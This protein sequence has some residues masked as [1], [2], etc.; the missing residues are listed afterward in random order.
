MEVLIQQ[1]LKDV[2]SN[3]RNLGE[4]DMS[5]DQC[6]DFFREAWKKKKNTSSISLRDLETKLAEKSVLVK[7]EEKRKK[8]FWKQVGKKPVSKDEGKLSLTIYQKLNLIF[9]RH[10]K[11]AKEN[12][13][14]TSKEVTTLQLNYESWKSKQ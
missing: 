11:L 12:F 13:V 10:R 14:K 2:E 5:Y 6:T 7:K 1:T 8:I 3:Y 4:N 9:E